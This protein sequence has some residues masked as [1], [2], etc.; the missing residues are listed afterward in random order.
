MLLFRRHLGHPEV[1][2]PIG[3]KITS[4]RTDGGTLMN[5]QT[6]LGMAALCLLLSGCAG[7]G[8]PPS[9]ASVSAG[10]SNNESQPEDT[11]S[12]YD[13]AQGVSS[14][15]ISRCASL[16]VGPQVSDVLGRSTLTNTHLDPATSPILA[17]T[18]AYGVAAAPGVDDYMT[19]DLLTV[20]VNPQGTK[21]F[22]SLVKDRGVGTVLP[23]GDEA[24]FYEGRII[25]NGQASGGQVSVLDGTTLITVYSWFQNTP[26]QFDS[27]QDQLVNLAEKALESSRN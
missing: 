17:C 27:S 2:K 5:G 19:R 12:H 23:L 18:F 20:S 24:H 6:T 13:V 15:H 8:T 3:S 14:A 25:G 16:E 1:G 26:P 21:T 7:A 22:E 4:N 10:P 11:A 9:E